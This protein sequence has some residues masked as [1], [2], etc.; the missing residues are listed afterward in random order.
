ME[1]AKQEDSG[2]KINETEVVISKKS[3]PEIK[4]RDNSSTEE[5]LDVSNLT[6][7]ISVTGFQTDDRTVQE[8]TSSPTLKPTTIVV[9]T[10]VIPM[11]V[12]NQIKIDHAPQFVCP[13]CPP[14][15]QFNL[16]RGFKLVLSSLQCCPII[17]KLALGQ[18][19]Q[20]IFLKPR[21]GKVLRPLYFYIVIILLF[22][23][24]KIKF[25]RNFENFSATRLYFL[26]SRSFKK[27]CK[28]LKILDLVFQ[29]TKNRNIWRM[30]IV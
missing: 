4:P 6:E 3:P 16:R 11:I 20:S 27:S 22:I 15:Y 8:K 30:S 12:I 13:R 10:S 14:C 25:H 23:F 18:S 7:N 2:A 1:P 28:N 17:F 21:L 9:K 24:W 26:M 29:Q 5:K 19:N